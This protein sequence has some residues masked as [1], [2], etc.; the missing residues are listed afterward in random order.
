MSHEDLGDHLKAGAISRSVGGPIALPRTTVEIVIDSGCVGSSRRVIENC[1]PALSHTT[2]DVLADLRS[3]VGAMSGACAVVLGPRDHLGAPSASL[4][5]R[6]RSDAP[7]V[8]V[9]VVADG[10]A[11]IQ[12]WLGR[13]ARAGTDEVY[14]LDSEADRRSFTDSIRLR[15]SAPPPEVALRALWTHWIAL[16]V[17]TQAIHFVR[18]GH[19]LSDPAAHRRWFG[20]SEKAMRARFRVL[21]LPTPWMLARVGRQLHVKELH[22]RGNLPLSDIATRLGF[23]TS[24]QLSVDRRRVRRTVREWPFLHVLLEHE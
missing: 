4:I 20:I 15:V 3:D 13:Y 7:H 19:R 23:E 14:C 12:P 6:L 11:E 9:F 8:G 18:N 1:L 5:E 22:E 21:G 16:A 2:R 17:R 24:L 10:A